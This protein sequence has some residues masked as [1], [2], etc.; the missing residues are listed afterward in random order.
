MSDDAAAGWL[1]FCARA[2]T[3][4]GEPIA[5]APVAPERGILPG[6]A[7]LTLASDSSH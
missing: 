6:F 3:P 5:E 4:F 1:F 7:M 2:R